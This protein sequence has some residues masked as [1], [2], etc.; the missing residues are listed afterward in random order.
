MSYLAIYR[1]FRP[2]TFEEMIGQEH[3]V[4][5]LTNQITSGRI[6]HAYLFCGSRGTG[7]TTTAKIFA[8][9]I[10][11]EH[12]VNGSPCGKCDTCK[13]LSD[14][15]NL[16]ILEMDAASNN[17]VENV[18]EIRDKVQYPPVAGKYK[19][20][21]IDEVHMLTTEAFNALLKTLE[22][23]PAHAVFIL[24]TTEQHKLPATILS[25]CMRF[26]FK[27]VSDKLI[28]ERI[29]KIYREV[30]KDYEKEAVMRIAAAGEGCVR[31]ALSI[32]DLC[33]SY[34]GEKLTY[35]DVIDVLGAS[36]NTTTYK[37]AEGIFSGQT[38]VAV[39]VTEELCA[40]GKS[41]ALMC[42]DMLNVLRD[43]L[44]VKTCKNY[45]EILS[46]P[47][48]EL[49][50]LKKLSETADEHRLLRILEIFSSLENELKY[51]SHPRVIFETAVLKASAPQ[52]D[53]DIDALLSRIS[54]L[55][56]ELANLREN[57]VKVPVYV[58]KR[59]F[60]DEQAPLNK[61]DEKIDEVPADENAVT[62]DESDNAPSISEEIAPPEDTGADTD[63][64][65]DEPTYYDDEEVDG[66]ADTSFDDFL[67]RDLASEDYYEPTGPVEGQIPFDLDAPT[68]V[69]APEKSETVI[70]Q[71]EQPQ[72][73]AETPQIKS[74]GEIN[75][76]RLW[77]TLLRRLRADK[78]IM[79]WIA[80]Q[81]AEPKISGNKLVISVEGEN[82]LK[83]LSKPDNTAIIKKIVSEEYDLQ[84]EFGII[85]ETA[86]EFDE[87]VEKVKKA[88][89]KVEVV[90]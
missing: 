71:A 34:S 25:R 43:V 36:D 52:E 65:T 63:A 72:P 31:D 28:A 13:A 12:P 85:G 81:D 69:S 50:K 68:A 59:Q 78:N 2:A 1:K 64:D 35:N 29:E 3:I 27:L 89:G 87:D 51:S 88:L 38:S 70:K 79:L 67:N 40:S 47:Q 45:A 75:V 30:G 54:K 73:K 60:S 6:G 44:I 58:D 84:I 33:L 76:N 86:D 46:L 90:D 23:P 15:A 48:G 24:A 57:G 5:T 80:C 62:V 49:D 19:V 61:S 32:A 39:S 82:E 8:K 7:K 41:V 14:P 56:K 77:G 16:D 17:K 18:R 20:Y 4:K 42:K 22:E 74:V 11:C 26:D 55:E 21:I 53:Y 83:L 66:P 9:A 37:L 10:N